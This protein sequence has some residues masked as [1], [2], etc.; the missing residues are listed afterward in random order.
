[1]FIKVMGRRPETIPEPQVGR[2]VELYET[3]GGI[4]YARCRSMLGDAAAAEDICQETFLRVYLHMHSIPEPAGV[5]PWLYR[6]A[7]NLCLNAIRDGRARPLLFDVP[8]EAEGASLEDLLANRELAGR[9][10][11]RVSPKVGVAAWLFY[12][13]GMRQEEMAALLGISRRAVAK[14]LSQFLRQSRKCLH[15]DLS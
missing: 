7:T 3:Y 5:L 8:P 4:V 1:V 11:A 13:D 10:I 12:V 9:L 2:V 15:K 14:R 6:I